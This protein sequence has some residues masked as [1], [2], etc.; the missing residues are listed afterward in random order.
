M[1][2]SHT[3]YL[4]SADAHDKDGHWLYNAGLIIPQP[5]RGGE[6]VYGSCTEPTCTM[7]HAT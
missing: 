3:A 1:T 6:D 4:R 5:M 7:Y 2:N